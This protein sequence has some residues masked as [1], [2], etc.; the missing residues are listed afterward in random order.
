[1]PDL[2]INRM[3]GGIFVMVTECGELIQSEKTVFTACLGKVEDNR[4]KFTLID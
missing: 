4:W 3:N 2:R 1:M